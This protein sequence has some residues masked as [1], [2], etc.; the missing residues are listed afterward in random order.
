VTQRL[1]LATPAHEFVGLISGQAKGA[2]VP[3]QNAPIAVHE[4]H[5]IAHMVQQIFIETRVGLDH[6]A[7]PLSLG[8]VCSPPSRHRL[9]ASLTLEGK[10]TDTV[11]E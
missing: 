2:F 10:A 6:S 3:V 8:P 4:V 7:S 9:A 11:L 5:A 1:V